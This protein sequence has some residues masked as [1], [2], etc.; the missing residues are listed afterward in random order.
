MANDK[1]KSPRRGRVPRPGAIVHYRLTADDYA[2]VTAPG[3]PGRVGNNVQE[4][5]S[6]PMI[7]TN[8]WGAEPDSAFNGQCFLDGNDSLWVTSTVIGSQIGEC[9]WEPPQTA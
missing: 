3:E 2:R 5:D 6:F 9:S 7:I 4:G 1:V 8:V